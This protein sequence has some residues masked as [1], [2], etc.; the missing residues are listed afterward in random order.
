MSHI[1]LLIYCTAAYPYQSE[2]GSSSSTNSSTTTLLVEA[3]VEMQKREGGGMHNDK[4]CSVLLFFK[5]TLTN[6]AGSFS[7]FFLLN[8]FSTLQDFLDFRWILYHHH[9]AHTHQHTPPPPP[10]TTHAQKPLFYKPLPFITTAMK[11][12]QLGRTINLC[13]KFRLQILIIYCK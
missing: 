6:G 10:A 13:G 5:E 11:E 2:E 3:V 8:F 12:V 4:L 7:V 9:T 1:S